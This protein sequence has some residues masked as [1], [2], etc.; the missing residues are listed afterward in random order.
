MTSQSTKSTTMK[1]IL[2]AFFAILMTGMSY[3]QGSKVTGFRD[4]V[5]GI[6]KDSVYSKGVKQKFDKDKGASEANSFVIKDDNLTLGA[7]KLTKISYHFNNQSRFKK[8]VMFGNQKYVQDVRE[9]LIFKFGR[10]KSVKDP[11][12]NLKVHEWQ[13]GDV[14][15][16][17]TQ[18]KREENFQLIIE[19]NWDLSE[20]YVKNMNVNDIVLEKDQIIGFR[21][22]KWLDKKDSVYLNGEKVQFR[23]DR[24][25][26][27]LNTYYLDAEKLSFGAA[28]LS[29][30]SYFFNEDDK[31]TK[32]VLTGSAD[33]FDDMKFILNHKFGGAEDENMFG[34]EM[35]VTEWVVGDTTLKLANRSEGDGGFSLIIESSRDQTERYIKNTK[36]TDF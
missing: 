25:A 36:V 17:L 29:G 11:N 13:E 2:I 32:V 34:V 24:E 20:T 15:I 22:F 30:I 12:A 9:I 4:L 21:D 23:L 35:S 33:Y 27:Q 3:G 18:N 8:V 10:A 6:H 5:W 26:D 7:A 28:R 14:S 31:L 1:Q 19:S 16:S